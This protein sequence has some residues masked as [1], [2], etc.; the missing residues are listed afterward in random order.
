MNQSSDPDHAESEMVAAA[1][2]CRIA[3]H[4]VCAIALL[5]GQAVERSM[6][7]VG[8]ITTLDRDQNENSLPFIL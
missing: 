5:I 1:T 6:R 2:R 4:A 7:A 8:F 3:E